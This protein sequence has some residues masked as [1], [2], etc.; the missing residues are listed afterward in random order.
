MRREPVRPR[1]G[2]LALS[3]ELARVRNAA[4]VLMGDAR[5]PDADA[6]VIALRALQLAQALSEKATETLGPVVDRN[7]R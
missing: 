2:L 5:R 6:G 3:V 7:S 4:D 1:D